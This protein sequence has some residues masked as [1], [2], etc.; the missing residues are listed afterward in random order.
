MHRV[1]AAAALALVQLGAQAQSG[2]APPPAEPGKL[3]TVTVTAE[4]RVEVL[5]DVPSSISA[6]RGDELEALATSG[7]DVRQLAGRAPSLNIE[8]SFGRAFPRFYIRGLGNTDFDLNASQPVSLLLDDVVQ[9]NP[10]LKGFPMFDVE[11]VEVLRGPQGTQYGRNSPAGVVKFDSV[12]PGRK[13]E[14]YLSLS[15]GTFG[16]LNA[17]GAFNLPLGGDWAARFSAISQHR[18]NWV[19]NTRTGEKLEGYDDNAARMQVLWQPTK[20]FSALANL[21]GRSLHGTA[22]LFRANLFKPGT[23]DLV[24]GFDPKRVAYDGVNE[25]SLDSWG[26]SLKLRWELGGGM[27]LT[28]IT[29]YE[30]VKAFSRGDIDGGF[31]AEF[32]GAGNYGPGRIPFAA[33]S[34]DGMPKHHQLTQELRLQSTGAGPLQWLGGLYYFNEKLNIDSFNFDSLA[35]GNPRNGYA[36]QQQK[37]TAWAVF[38]SVNYEL[39][40]QLKL[41]A[42]LRYTKDKKDFVADRITAPPF[43]PTFIG[44]LTTATNASNTSGDLAL[45]WALDKTTNVYGRFATGFRAPSIQGRLLFGDTLSVADSEKV[46]SYEA[47]I[48]TDFWDRRASV[49]ASVFR[50]TIKD[51][52]LTAVGG[53]ANFN[54]LINAAKTVGQGLELDARALVTDRLLLKASLSIN[55]TKIKDPNLYVQPCNGGCTVLD[56]AGPTAGTVSIYNNPL[57]QAPKTVVNLAARYGAPTGNGGEWYIYTDW[58]YRSKVNFFL[59]EAAEFSSKPLLEGGL[60]LGYIWADGKYEAAIYGRNIA[61]QVRAVGAIDFNNVTGFINDPRT[62]GVQFRANF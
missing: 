2:D 58:S 41:R 17:Q 34:A 14:G 15:A 23:N 7:M 49:S 22:R 54:Q 12:R 19:T 29:G 45:T 28:S 24:D 25:Q 4:R 55:D 48:K 53:A 43:S 33:E 36:T 46:T 30:T 27:A 51:H 31:G 13:Q 40:S 3:Q 5:R 59:Y 26:G 32:L 42:G 39:T 20:E 38:G 44:Q 1:A 6:L 16:T 10:I 21:H 11:Q 50:Y 56:P 61:N 57:P 9:E 62:W 47:G 18:N 35:A 37:N 60:R 8:S 52:Q